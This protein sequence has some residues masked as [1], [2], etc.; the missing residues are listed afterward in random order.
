MRASWS[1][2]V[3]VALAAACGGST[4]SGNDATSSGASSADGNVCLPSACDAQQTPAH[5]CVGGVPSPV[6]VAQPNG[7]CRKQIDCVKPDPTAPPDMRGLSPCD[8][9]ACGP[10]PVFDPADCRYGFA[11]TAPGCESIDRGACTW[12]R[13]CRPK[14]CSVAEGTCNTVDTSRL[15][16]PCGLDRPCPESSSC[17]S[18]MVDIGETIGPVCITGNPCTAVTCGKGKSCSTRASY[19]AQVV[20]SSEP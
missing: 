15:G 9:A 2:A 20:C 14:P 8:P 5:E 4:S 19:P 3:A 11:G 6:C 18:I 17:A 7:A 13:R 1:F 10:E 12:R 16:G